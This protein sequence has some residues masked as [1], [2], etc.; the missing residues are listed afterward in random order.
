MKC[1][2]VRDLLPAYAVSALDAATWWAVDVHLQRCPRCAGEAQPLL[3]GA[4]GLSAIAAAGIALPPALKRRVLEGIGGT[5]RPLPH[6]SPPA[7]RGVLTGIAL[8]ALLAVILGLGVGVFH[9]QARLQGQIEDL[10]HRLRV[11]ETLQ[12]AR[13]AHLATALLAMQQREDYRTETLARSL[14]DLRQLV[15]WSATSDLRIIGVK[16][17]P[18]APTA[19][20]VLMAPPEGRVALLVILGLA[21]LPPSHAYQV[22]LV[23]GDQRISGGTFTVD[24]AGWAQVLVHPPEPLTS[25]DGLRV[26]IEPLQGSLTPTGPLVLAADLLRR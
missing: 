17:T 18:S 23:Q 6:P 10:V 14:H 7:W 24:K 4:M 16:G 9:R 12:D 5:R 15:Y 3:E 13:L 19:Y 25:F 8:A 20:G 21:P 26:T 2:R 22:W 1:G 11:L